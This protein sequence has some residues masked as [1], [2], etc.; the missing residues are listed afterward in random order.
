MPVRRDTASVDSTQV[1]ME[2]EELL[3][4]NG[5]VVKESEVPSPHNAVKAEEQQ[6]TS[7]DN[8]PKHQKPKNQQMSMDD[9]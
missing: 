7:A 8:K 2:D 1:I 3:D 6:K 5:N 4:E 9:F